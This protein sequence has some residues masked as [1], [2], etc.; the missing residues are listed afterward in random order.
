MIAIEVVDGIGEPETGWS[1]HEDRPVWITPVTPDAHCERRDLGQENI[2]SP[3]CMLFKE[4][5]DECCE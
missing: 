3:I 5:T 4:V 1:N 2:D